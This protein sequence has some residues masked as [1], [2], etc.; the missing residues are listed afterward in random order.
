MINKQIARVR[1]YKQNRDTEKVSAARQR[2]ETAARTNVNLMPHII[3]C[4]DSGV[5]LGEISDSLRTVFGTH[6]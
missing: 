4:A 6:S 3:F 1:N 2:L 5:T